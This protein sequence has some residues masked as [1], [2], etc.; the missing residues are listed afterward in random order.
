MITRHYVAGQSLPEGKKKIRN[1]FISQKPHVSLFNILRKG[2]NRYNLPDIDRVRKRLLIASVELPG[3]TFVLTVDGKREVIKLAPNDYFKEYC[4]GDNGDPTEIIIVTAKNGPE[5]FKASLCYS[6]NGTVAP[7][8]LT[9]VNL[10]HVDGGGTH[11]NYFLDVLK[12]LF[13]PAAKKMGVKFHPNDCLCG[14]RAYLSLSLKE[15]EF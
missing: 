13:L 14:L 2:I 3:C 11:V 12:G 1:Y 6:L 9:S 5:T 8:I 15:P 10:L 4:I 7:K